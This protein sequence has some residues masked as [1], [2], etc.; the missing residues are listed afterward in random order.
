MTSTAPAIDTARLRA[1]EFP[2]T[3]RWAYLSHASVGPLP[4]RTVRA[5][6]AINRTFTTPHIWEAGERATSG[7]QAREA[8]AGLVGAP[9]ERITFVASAG[10]GVSVCAAGVDCAPGDEVVIP[11]AEYPSLA[12]PFLAQAYRGLRVRW[13]PK[14]TDGRTSLDAI[15]DA[16]TPRTRAV[17]ISHVEYADGYRNDLRQLAA[18]CR[19]RDALLIVDATQSMGAVPLDVDGWGVHAVVAHGYKWL[20]AGFGVGVMALSEEGLA[21]IRPT[22]AGGRSVCRNPYVDEPVLDWQPDASRFITGEPPH[23]LLAGLTASLTLVNEVGHPRVLPHAQTLLDQLAAGVEAKGYTVASDLTPERRSTIMAITAGSPEADTR[24]HVA[25]SEA[26]VITALRPRG[27]R[28]APT[29]Y[30]DASDIER[31]LDALPQR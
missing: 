21:R 10:H 28:V 15:A 23:T 14:T 22:H 27:I 20:H 9:P 4:Q 11:H 16:I 13:V 6:D 12:V 18:L 29:F 24:A 25:L 1:D 8:L 2:M 31:L 5:L 30:N 7:C 3:E 17:A 19:E 26:G